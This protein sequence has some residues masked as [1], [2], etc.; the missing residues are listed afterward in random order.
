L[1]HDVLAFGEGL[2]RVQAEDDGRIEDAVRFSAFPGGAELNT[3]FALA[4]LGLDAAWFSVLPEGPLGRRVLRHLR[5]AGVDC[6]LVRTVPG[7]LGTYWVEYGR[8]P[9]TIEVLYDRKDSTVCSV[10]RE[11]APWDALRAARLFF[12]S[13]ITPAL[14]P[15]CRDLALEMAETA[16][17]SGVR[18]ATDLNFRARLWKPDVAAPVLDRLAKA[19]DI[20]ITAEDDLRLLFGMTGDSENVAWCALE[21]F[22]ARTIVVTRGAEGG[23]LAQEGAIH[24]CAVFPSIAT[25]RIGAGDAFTAGFLYAT[26]TGREERALDFGLAMAALKHSLPGDTLLTTPEEVERVAARQEAGIRR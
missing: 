9:R 5:S 19:A 20:I 13:G 16:Q 18:V 14:S 3:C 10:R 17:A 12:V 8:Q 15:A 25:D 4:N 7:R 23:L 24:H 1:G 6:S 26:L 11:D 22:K 2:L 21:H